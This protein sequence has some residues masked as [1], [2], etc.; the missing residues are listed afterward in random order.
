MNGREIS[1]F[2]NEMGKPSSVLVR[3]E[4]SPEGR[5]SYLL[6]GPIGKLEAKRGE[7]DRK[8]PGFQWE[9]VPPVDV[10]LF[11]EFD[12][13]LGKPYLR[14]LAAKVALEQF[15][16]LLPPSSPIPT[17]VPFGSS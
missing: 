1:A 13:D 17:F 7:I 10:K 15:A 14:R 4:T 3:P 9:D 5:F 2:L 6:Y 16:Q 8:Y 12:G 11:V